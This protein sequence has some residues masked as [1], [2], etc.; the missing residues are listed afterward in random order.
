MFAINEGACNVDFLLKITEEALKEL[1]KKVVKVKIEGKK[2][3]VFNSV[4]AYVEIPLTEFAHKNCV[5]GVVESGGIKITYQFNMRTP[6]GRVTKTKV[7]TIMMRRYP[8]Y[9]YD[10]SFETDFLKKFINYSTS[11]TPIENPKTQSQPQQSVATELPKQQAVQQP[12]VPLFYVERTDDIIRKFSAIAVQ[13][14]T[15]DNVIRPEIYSDCI[16]YLARMDEVLDKAMNHSFA[17]KINKRLI[18]EIQDEIMKKKGVLENTRKAG[19]LPNEVYAN[20]LKQ[21]IQRDQGLAQ[22]FNMQ[23]YPQMTAFL[24]AR[25]QITA[26]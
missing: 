21:N 18:E 2:M 4:L 9:V 6:R 16:T 12:L 7:E 22:V 19:R 24:N 1:T 25:I 3:V 20:L 23:G 5:E 11:V 15:A 26:Q 10:P 14:F 13:G 17:A 8:E